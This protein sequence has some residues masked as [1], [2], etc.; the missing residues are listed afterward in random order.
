MLITC[1]R[2]LGDKYT[3]RALIE[4]LRKANENAIA[5]DIEEDLKKRYPASCN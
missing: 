5:S 4:A 3:W 1:K 2:I